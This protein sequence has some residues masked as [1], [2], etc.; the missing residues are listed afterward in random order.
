MAGRDQPNLREL[1]LALTGADA[2]IS[3]RVSGKVDLI[4]VEK[5]SARALLK[6]TGLMQQNNEDLKLITNSL[7]GHS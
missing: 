1:V 7:K 5:F 3:T 4:S 6:P 2:I